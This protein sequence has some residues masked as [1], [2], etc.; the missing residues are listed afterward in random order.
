MSRPPTTEVE[1]KNTEQKDDVQEILNCCGH[2]SLSGQR[3]CILRRP[4]STIGV[5]KD[6]VVAQIGID[7][8][9]V[10]TG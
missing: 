5:G 2:P 7:N 9:I 10:V 3:R 8:I 4:I 1:V 6:M